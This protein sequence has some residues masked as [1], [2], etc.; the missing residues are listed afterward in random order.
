[1]K[2]EKKNEM[3]KNRFKKHENNLKIIY[4]NDC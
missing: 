2:N 4:E 3:K 1:M